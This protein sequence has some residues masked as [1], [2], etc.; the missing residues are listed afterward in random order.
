MMSRIF[1]VMKNVAAF[2]EIGR[3]GS[4][5]NTRELVVSGTPFI[6]VYQLRKQIVVH[7]ILHSS[8][9]WPKLDKKKIH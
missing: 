3:I 8:R 2:P 9:K 1:E 7:R 4:V 6:L 5:E